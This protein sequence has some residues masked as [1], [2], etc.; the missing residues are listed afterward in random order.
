MFGVDRVKLN[1]STNII[2]F[3]ISIVVMLLLHIIFIFSEP[4]NTMQE[5][6]PIYL[7]PYP[8]WVS[9]YTILFISAI[10][11]IFLIKI[12]RLIFLIFTILGLLIVITQGSITLSPLQNFILQFTCSLYGIIIYIAFFTN[13]FDK[14]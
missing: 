5:I 14:K 11:M 4:L 6:K 13:I 12:F 8:I 2:F 1:H 9:I 3:R 10:S 7:I